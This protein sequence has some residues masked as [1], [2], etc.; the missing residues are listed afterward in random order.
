M[1][2]NHNF[3][4]LKNKATLWLN[5]RCETLDEKTSNKITPT[6]ELLTSPKQLETLYLKIKQENK[7]TFL[8]ITENNT[9]LGISL[10]LDNDYSYYLPISNTKE[11]L[12]L[13]STP[14]T[15]NTISKNKIK[16]FLSHLFSLK[17]I[18]KISPNLK[19]NLHIL[20]EHLSLDTFPFPYDDILVMSYDINSSS[21][22]HDLKSLSLKYLNQEPKLNTPEN[23]KLKL[24]EQQNNALL[25]LTQHNPE[26]LHVQDIKIRKV[27]ADYMYMYNDHS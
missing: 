12:D 23:S 1:L 2:E 8:P 19:N 13:F 9:L 5:K 15:T 17:E 4:S 24:A 3:K 27:L 11:E 7:F 10:G 20:R 6:Y 21:I 26:Y 22:T 18:L 25:P 16:D 14:N